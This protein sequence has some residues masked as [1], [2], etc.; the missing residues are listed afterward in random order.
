MEKPFKSQWLIIMSPTN[1]FHLLLK[2]YHAGHGP[3]IKMHSM[4][5]RFPSR[6]GGWEGLKTFFNLIST[7][8]A[9]VA[10]SNF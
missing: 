8:M 2:G 6:F 3:F 10:F 7:S 5:C 1:P 4:S 9:R